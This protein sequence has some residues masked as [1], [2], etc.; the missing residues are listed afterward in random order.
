MNDELEGRSVVV[1]GASGAVGGEIVV[2][3]R[4][5]GAVV[6]AVARS[7]G[8]LHTMAEQA[9]GTR[10]LAIDATLE[11]APAA[12]F[13]M[14]TPDVLVIAA[15]ARPPAGAMYELD[16]D[17]FCINWQSDVKMTF[18]FL[19]AALL[20]PLPPGSCVIVIASGAA[21]AGSPHSGGYAPSKRV[22][23]FLA[24]YA[25]KE[26]NRLGRGLR[27]TTLAPRM[28]PGT[29][30]GRHAAEGYARYLGITPSD[31]VSSLEAAP[32]PAHVATAALAVA[33]DPEAFKGRALVVDATGMK[34]IP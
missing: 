26:S 4:A 1:L 23:M 12:V 5:R 22:Q 9:R 17:E 8:P 27:I 11:R 32:E 7:A 19:R 18:L 28:M 14:L 31:F 2:R 24:N 25:Q 13:D 3:A 33:A 15:G 21:L 34:P 16:W 29:P 30:L 20:R 6:L 10:V